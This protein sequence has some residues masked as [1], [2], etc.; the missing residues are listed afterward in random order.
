MGNKYTISVLTGDR[1]GIVAAISG[2]VSELD[3]NILAL[4]QTVVSDYFTIILVVEFPG[5]TTGSQVEKAI[6][7]AGETGEFSVI[8]RDYVDSAGRPGPYG[9]ITPKG[10]QYVLTAH[11]EDT[12][13]LIYQISSSLAKKGINILDIAVYMKGGNV[14]LVAQ[15]FVPFETDLPRLRQDLEKLEA[16]PEMRIHLQH[17]DIFNQTNRI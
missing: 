6:T 15:L 9:S 12:R 7:D 14:V 13:G 4:S 16:N 10:E 17:I 3:G 11:G 2:A 5:S 8:V 1:P